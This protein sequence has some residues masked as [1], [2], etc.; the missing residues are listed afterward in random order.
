[1]KIKA[2]K[3]LVI[4]FTVLAVNIPY[5]ASAAT[6]AYD[7]FSYTGTFTDSSGAGGS[8][9]ANA[10]STGWNTGSNWAGSSSWLFGRDDNS[11]IARVQSTA[12]LT[13]G[14]NFATTTAGGAK[15]DFNGATSSGGYVVLQRQLG[16]TTPGSTFYFGYLWQ[17]DTRNLMGTAHSADGTYNYDNFNNQFRPN[18]AKT[19]VV[20]LNGTDDTNF[21]AG[22][23]VSNSANAALAGSG[24]VA[25]ALDTT[26]F[27]LSRVTNNGAANTQIDTWTLS[28]ADFNT[29]A[30]DQNI[31]EAELDANNQWM[32]TNTEVAGE[33]FGGS[34]YFQY[35]SHRGGVAEIDEIRY[36]TSFNDFVAIPE[37]SSAM[38][39]GL[40]LTGLLL[41]RRRK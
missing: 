33:T 4:A 6:L 11:R 2:S 14:S 16:I 15:I 32:R 24:S 37:P 36:A 9:V 38:L 35:A 1:M 26:Y 12:G 13:F 21:D 19:F 7:G 30:G 29:V 25:L 41:L 27:T 23:N 22:N 39:I 20:A 18:N 28:L 5:S 3:I 31:T 40:G 17:S 34:E 10:T 8:S